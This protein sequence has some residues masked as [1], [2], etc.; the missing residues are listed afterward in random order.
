MF[1]LALFLVF[2]V[3]ML[4][5]VGVLAL[6]LKIQELRW[7]AFFRASLGGVAAVPVEI[8]RLLTAFK[9]AEWLGATSGESAQLLL[10]LLNLRLGPMPLLV[11]GGFFLALQSDA[12]ATP[13]ARPR[14]QSEEKAAPKADDVERVPCSVCGRPFP[15]EAAQRTGGI[16]GS[17]RKKQR[18]EP[19]SLP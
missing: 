3:D 17:C 11:L 5:L 13:T 16:C 18:A 10:F 12:Q 15:R 19:A 4:A 2:V 7:P 14:A 9:L 6:G 8:A 1:Y